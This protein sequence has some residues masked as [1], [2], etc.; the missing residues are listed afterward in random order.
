MDQD[1][2]LLT[3]EHDP[4]VARIAQKYL[5]QDR[6]VSFHIE[7]AALFLERSAS[8]QY[9]LIFADTWA[10]KYTHLDEALK[11]IRAGGGFMWLMIC[12]RSL[13]GPMTMPPK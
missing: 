9:D 7:D 10:G 12:F 11:L 1:S 13:I 8:Q 4:K 3:V 5:G 2:Q 6:R